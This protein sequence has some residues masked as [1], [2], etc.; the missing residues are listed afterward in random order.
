MIVGIGV[1]IESIGRFSR[2]IERHGDR[3]LQKIFTREEIAYCRR[4]GRCEQHFAARFAAKEAVLK[5]LRY[6]PGGG[7]LKEIEV[8]RGE[9]GEPHIRLAGDMLA[10]ATK[11]RISRIHVSLSHADTHCVAQAV[12]E[13]DG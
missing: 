1:D 11:R 13:E 5:A 4:Q 9:H 2:A 6:G 12:A 3:F 10:L 7:S 8:V